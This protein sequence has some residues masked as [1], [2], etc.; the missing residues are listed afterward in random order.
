MA[1]VAHLEI[2]PGQPGPLG[3]TYDGFGVN[4]SV[5]S[6]VAERI[7]LCFF[8]EAGEETRVD[9]PELTSFCFHGYVPQLQPGQR[10]GFRVHG[11]WAP[12]HG[13]R[14]NPAKLLLDPYAKAIDGN[15]RWD[16]AVFAH[17]FADP[18]ARN[19]ADSAPFMSKAVVTNP[20]FDWD[21]DRPPRTPEHKTVIYEA[22]VKGFTK[23]NDRIPE[24]LRGTYAGL[25]QPAVVE[26]LQ[27]LGITAVELMPVHQ[28]VHDAAPARARPAQLLG[29]QLDRLLRAA[30][31]IQ[32]LRR[33]RPAGAGVPAD[34]EDPAPGRHRSDPRRRLQPHRRG[35]PPRAGAVVQGA[36]QRLVLPA[37]ARRPA[38]LPGLHRHRQQPQHAPPAGAA[39]DHGLAALLGDR[40]ARRRLPLRPRVGAGARAATRWIG[41]R[42]SST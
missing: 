27:R 28:F 24:E 17:R 35:Q 33:A 8:D 26:Y 37:V 29:V 10:Y 42:P 19:D 23:L 5:F 36:R 9:L 38:L 15:V 31:R 22:H 11:P 30:P 2:W 40:D 3:A 34:G 18:E 14:C 39:A 32:Q 16:E 12:E 6:E 25:A 4:F 1:A 41:C 13:H 7:E 21:V 20:W